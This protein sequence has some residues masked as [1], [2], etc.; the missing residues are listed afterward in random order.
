[1]WPFFEVVGAEAFLA[2][3]FLEVDLFAGAFLAVDFLLAGAFFAPDA[4]VV[5]SVDCAAVAA[6]AFSVA[7]VFFVAAVFFVELPFLGA[8]VFF[9]AAVRLRVFAVSGAC[10]PVFASSGEAV[11]V[12]VA[13]RDEAARDAVTRIPFSG[14][15]GGGVGGLVA[16]IIRG[17]RNFSQSLRAGAH[18][19]GR[20]VVVITGQGASRRIREAFG[21]TVVCAEP[22]GRRPRTTA[23]APTASTASS[24]ASATSCP[25]S[26]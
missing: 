9:A 6:S 7:E 10:A 14:V 25:G 19:S 11:G 16:I 12:V 5:P 17:P 18:T 23:W 26:V 2:V 8:V 1:M 21:P 3:D 24:T 15:P 13:V 4:D 22:P 20:Y